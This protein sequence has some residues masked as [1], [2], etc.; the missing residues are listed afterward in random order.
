MMDGKTF[1][2]MGGI[3]DVF[4]AMA[5]GVKSALDTIS[6]PDKERRLIMEASR[7]REETPHGAEPSYEQRRR[8][9]QIE[10]T[11]GALYR[12]DSTP[13]GSVS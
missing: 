3:G 8:L 5:R 7:I 12:D 13:N 4:C 11:M 1:P 9:R 6:A 10:E 2:R